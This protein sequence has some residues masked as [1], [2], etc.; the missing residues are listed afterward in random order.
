[1]SDVVS[2]LQ[3]DLIATIQEASAV[4]TCGRCVH[5]KPQSGGQCEFLGMGCA[6]T[7]LACTAFSSRK[8]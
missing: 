1:M 7:E 3:D 8:G 6:A 2:Q 5:W 4:P